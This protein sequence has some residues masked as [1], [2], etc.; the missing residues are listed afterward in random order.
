MSYAARKV[1]S[2]NL[3]YVRIERQGH[4]I[5]TTTTEGHLRSHDI[6]ADRPFNLMGFPLEIRLMIYEHIFVPQI[7]VITI[8]V[9]LLN[10]R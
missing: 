2:S 1:M 6:A 4:A 5:S 9:G 7:L 10:E 8:Q 3:N